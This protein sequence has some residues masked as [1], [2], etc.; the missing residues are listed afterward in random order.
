MNNKEVRNEGEAELEP[1]PVALFILCL[2]LNE[3]LP[4]TSYVNPCQYMKPRQV[5]LTAN[6]SLSDSSVLVLCATNAVEHLFVS[7]F[8]VGQGQADLVPLT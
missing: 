7:Y 5:L 8:E 6:Y 1:R 3:W 4:R 2:A